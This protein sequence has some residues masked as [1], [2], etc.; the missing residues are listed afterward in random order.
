MGQESAH[1]SK[2]LDVEEI[3]HFGNSECDRRDLV[4]T[5]NTHSRAIDAARAATA[6]SE[7][8]GE[9]FVYTKSYARISS[10]SY[11]RNMTSIA[12]ASFSRVAVTSERLQW[13]ARQAAL[14][15]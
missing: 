13:L 4:R 9:G 2:T 7:G 10:T 15:V 14:D 12:S 1:R 8:L 3:P 6:G 5:L 11:E